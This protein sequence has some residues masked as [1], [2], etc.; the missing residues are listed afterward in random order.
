MVAFPLIKIP[1]KY[2]NYY[3]LFSTSLSIA[4]CNLLSSIITDFVDTDIIDKL[5]D[6]QN[7]TD[8][9]NNTSSIA[10]N[11]TIL[12]FVSFFAAALTFV[13]LQLLVGV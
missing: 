4:I 6:S 2:N 13:L 9:N 11:R 3:L 12:F 10:L 1:Q 7:D 8:T 5:S